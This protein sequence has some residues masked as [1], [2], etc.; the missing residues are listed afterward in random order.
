MTRLL[1]S[2]LLL[3]ASPPVLAQ[4]ALPESASARQVVDWAVD[5]AG[6][7]AWLHATS[8]R[9]EGWAVLC[10][11]GRAEQCIR[12]D[13]Y[14][15]HRQ[16]PRDVAATHAGT[17]KFRLDAE[18]GE[19]VLFRA[20]F[21]GTRSYDAN[22]PLP[23]QDARSAEASAFGFSAIRFTD[24]PGF[25]LERLVDDEAE[26]HPCFTLKV[27]DATG[28]ATVFWI[29]RESGYIRKA[30]WDTPKGWHER[31]YSDFYWV[32]DPG[33]LQPGRV[34]L[35]YAGAKEVDI[36]WTSATLNETYDDALFVLGADND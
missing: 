27:V 6:G 4:G 24:A 33:F 26:G 2:L 25:K 29:D 31:V 21:D 23:P 30:A 35:Y 20:S 32:P 11:Q 22:G 17:G 34:R 14:V 1:L 28:S 5:R 18:V 3:S 7:E 10:R 15:M 16:Y 19:R 36:R 9:M 8:N 13:R 12:A